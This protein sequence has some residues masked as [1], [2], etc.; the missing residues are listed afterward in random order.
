[1][2]SLT[3][4]VTRSALEATSDQA[5]HRCCVAASVAHSMLHA[6]LLVLHAFL[7]VLFARADQARA[8]IRFA[9]ACCVAWL[10]CVCAWMTS[11]GL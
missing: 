10:V 9:K 5:L 7:L 6:F 4:S 11:S 3:R 2:L 8:D 1:M